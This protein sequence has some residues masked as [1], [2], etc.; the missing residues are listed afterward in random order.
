MMAEFNNVGLEDV[1]KLLLIQSAA[2]RKAAPLMLEAGARVLVAAQKAEAAKLNI[3]GRS[4]GAL[5]KS[6]KAGKVKTVGNSRII[7][8]SPQGIDRSHTKAG[9]R[10]AEKAFVL[11]YGRSDMPARAWMSAA[12]ELCANDVYKAE[13]EEWERVQ[14]ESG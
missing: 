12:N 14:N 13:L 4:K 9:V 1:E 2:V 3:S 11:E 5:V 10:N 8:I 6:I 7:E